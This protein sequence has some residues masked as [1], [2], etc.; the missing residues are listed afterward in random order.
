MTTRIAS[1]MI[2]AMQGR[3]IMSNNEI[4]KA[5]AQ[6]CAEHKRRIRPNLKAQIRDALQDYCGT[7]P[8]PKGDYFIHHRRG[9]WSCRDDIV[10]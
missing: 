9:Y 2:P 1:F 6:F 10:L 3:G 5:V 8:H 4:Y 7:Y